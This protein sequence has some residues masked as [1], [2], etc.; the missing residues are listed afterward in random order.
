VAGGDLGRSL[1]V[2]SR[3]EVGQLTQAFN[4]MLDGLRQRDFIRDTFG[5]YVSPD[6]A[7]ALLESPQG[8]KLGGEKRDVTVLMADLRGYTQFAE[9]ADPAEVVRM[10][11]GYL[12]RMTAIVTD[13]GG[14]INEFMGDGIRDLRKPSTRPITPTSRRVCHR[15]AGGHVEIG[16][17]RA[18]TSAAVRDGDRQRRGGGRQHRIEQRAKYG[19]VGGAVNSRRVSSPARS[20]ARCC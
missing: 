8:L 10:L 16:A 11:N 19:V 18:G 5:R 17:A 13:H 20:A 6:V 7:R 12:A 14:T 9:G 15:H 4:T 3:D 2:R 1:P